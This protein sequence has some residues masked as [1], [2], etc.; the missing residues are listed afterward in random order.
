MNDSKDYVREEGGFSIHSQYL[1]GEGDP[2]FTP[3]YHAYVYLGV[4][5]V[6][7]YSSA[8]VYFPAG[9]EDFTGI[10][11]R[12]FAERLRAVLMEDEDSA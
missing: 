8:A 5:A 2:E 11:V 9:I 10:D 6:F 7:E 3:G 4:T 1:D 12:K